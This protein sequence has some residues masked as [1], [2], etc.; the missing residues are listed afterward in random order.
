ME[1]FEIEELYDKLQS[2]RPVTG[3]ELVDSMWLP[4]VFREWSY[5]EHLYRTRRGIAVE[6][7]ER[8]GYLGRG[9]FGGVSRQEKVGSMPKEYRAVKEVERMSIT[10]VSDNNDIA[11]AM[12]R[13]IFHMA[14]LSKVCSFADTNA[15]RVVV[16]AM[17]TIPSDWFQRSRHFPD[18]Y[19]WYADDHMAYFA[20]EYAPHRDL[21]TCMK[22]L[23]REGLPR[24]E[25]DAK[26]ISRQLVFA[27]VDMHKLGIV[28]RDLKPEVNL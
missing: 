14:K 20:M 2:E 17:F 21:A 10:D 11:K 6:K 5:V 3:D 18:F 22:Q 27:L 26:E 1:T 12:R 28:H 15:H 4:T 24:S 19:G 13:E 23:G 7:W 8:A 9:S 25:D 16:N